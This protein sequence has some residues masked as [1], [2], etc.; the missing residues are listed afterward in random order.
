MLLARWRNGNMAFGISFDMEKALN[1]DI[2]FIKKYILSSWERCLSSGLL[3]ED[4]PRVKKITA[5]KLDR[6]VKQN[7]KLINAALI[8]INR[9]KGIIPYRKSIIMLCNEEC[10]IF[11]KL[12]CI[13]ELDELGMDVGYI[14]SEENIGSNS[15]GT[16]VAAK[17]PIAVL[18]NQ[19]FLDVFKEWAG[20]AVPIHDSNYEILG[21]LGLYTPSE[22]ASY[23]ILEMLILSV[24]GIEEQMQ[25]INKNMELETLNQKLLEFNSDIINTASMIAHEIRNSLS[26]ISAYVQLLQL[27]S[28]L[29]RSRA[30]IILTEVTHVNKLLSDFKTLTKPIQFNFIRC[31]LNLLLKNIVDIMTPKAQMSMVDIKLKMLDNHIYVRIDK[32]SIQEAFVNLIENAIQAMEKGGTLTIRLSRD[33]ALGKAIIEFEDTGVGIREENMD[34]IFKL[35]FTTKKNGSGLGLFLCKNTIRNH[36]GDIRVKSKINEGTTFYVEL[37]SID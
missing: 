26:T 27:E 33:Q 34:Q 31:S 4:M 6:L 7:Q 37:P 14:V 29:D 22:Y 11:Y 17:V 32:D 16:C 9:I 3:P 21:A 8:Y 13:P 20:F 12:G 18:G 2:I 5:Q 24:K 35:F 1:K 19:H 36:N 30:D 10:A 15:L 28:I 25:L 23:N